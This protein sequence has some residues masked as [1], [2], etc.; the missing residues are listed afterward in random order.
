MKLYSG[1]VSLFSR[2][3]E[4]ALHEKG[5]PFEQILVP[6]T[7]TGG[8]SPRNPDVLAINPKGQVPV[9]VD[10]DL[11]VYDS[12]VILEYLDEAYPEPALHPKTPEDRARCRLFDVFGDE[13]MLAPL[14]SLMHRTEP[15]PD[16][17]QRWDAQEAKAREAEP[18]LAGHFAEID[19]ALRGKDY[20]CGAFSAADI[21]VFMA[22]FWTRRLGGP[23]LREHEALAAWYERL[24]ARPAFARVIAE[25]RAADAELSAPVEGAFRE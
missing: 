18:V 13:V 7:Q 20:L 16:N 6:F 25:I 22:V 15:K 2:K 24:C 9:L 14:R 17:M 10:G 5:L 12:T 1:P 19:R 23:S 4:I 11:S 21:A 3:V 8:Y